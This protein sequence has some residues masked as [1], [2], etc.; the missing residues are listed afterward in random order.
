[1]RA[2]MVR[3]KYLNPDDRG[4]DGKTF[5]WWKPKRTW[6]EG[7][8]FEDGPVER[9]LDKHMPLPEPRYTSAA[10]LC[11]ESQFADR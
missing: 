9:V 3:T 6:P 1:M 4:V 10:S 8:R 11:I 2:T 5:H 7:M